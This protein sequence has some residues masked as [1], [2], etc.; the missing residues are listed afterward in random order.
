MRWFVALIGIAFSARAGLATAGPN[1]VSTPAIHAAASRAVVALETSIRVWH[2]NR[3]C[4]S[5]HHQGL[6]IVLTAEARTRG[7]AIDESLARRN[8]SRGLQ[9]LKSLD[10]AVQNAQQIDPAVDTGGMLVAAKA[11]GVPSGLVREV[12]ATTVANRQLADGSWQTLDN[13]PPQ[14]FSPVTATAIAVTAVRAYA[15]AAHAAESQERTRRAL[16]WLLATHPRDT[17]ERAFQILGAVEAGADRDAVRALC[18]SLLTEQR[19]DGGWAQLPSR[20]SDAY[21]TGEALVALRSA[22]VALTDPGFQRGLA[23]LLATQH[24]DGTWRVETRMHEQA[25]VSPPHFEIGFPY[26]EHQMISAI[27]TSWALRALFQA[28]PE[29]RM[30][31][32]PLVT[33]SEWRLEGEAPWMPVAISGSVADLE[34]LLEGGLDPNSHTTGGTTVLMMAAGDHDKV[35]AL[36]RHGADVNLAAK[37]GFTP[38]IV[39]ANDPG[40]ADAIR[41]LVDH[42][43]LV[44]PTSPK[45]LHDASPLFFA[46]WAGNVETVRLLLDR[47][48]N[49]RAKMNVAGIF[50]LTPLEI[51]VLQG[52]VA[53]VRALNPTPADINR[54]S[55]TGISSLTAAVMANRID[56]VRTLIAMGAKVNDVD[57]LSMTPLMHAALVD[58]GDTAVVELLLASGAQ[59][60]ATS[61]DGLTALDFARRQGHQA[62]A[63][64]LAHSPPGN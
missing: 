32:E 20:Q 27:A 39:A 38:L 63:R 23:Y 7:I 61:K 11:A 6:P 52:D 47:G 17:E 53:M 49:P 4:F 34:R 25:I 35:S 13:R 55:E 5:C 37:T 60:K 16:R 50:A 54:L 57:E 26:G 44:T 33:P 21:A 12:Y 64:L 58:F 48:A 31:P 56:M 10:R 9:G 40:A 24:P 14:S 8:I 18:T 41:V 2:Q 43:A 42:G 30:V 51:A 59:T 15:P 29:R 22:G 19:P 36:I 45:P 1:P 28:L 62:A 3:T 46:A